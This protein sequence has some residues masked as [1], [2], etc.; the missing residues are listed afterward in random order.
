MQGGSFS[1]LPQV[2]ALLSQQSFSCELVTK[3]ANG[4]FIDFGG[5][6]RTYEELWTRR[7]VNIQGAIILA[8]LFE[9]LIGLSGIVGV[10]MRFIGPLTISPVICLIGLSVMEPAIEKASQNWVI[11]CFC[12]A[13]IILCSQILNEIEFQIGGVKIPIF[14]LFP[15]LIGLLTS[16]ILCC[17]IT[18]SVDW[19]DHL[20]SVSFQE[21]FYVQFDV[22]YTQNNSSSWQ[23]IRI[24]TRLGVIRESNWIQVRITQETIFRD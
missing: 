12:I 8:G 3:T 5:V 11:S 7:M 15:V 22:I 4:T 24:D 20:T 18:F 16:Y 17:I 13:I 6:E 23:N 1:F 21:I 14:G 2:I 19:E 9:F 10:I